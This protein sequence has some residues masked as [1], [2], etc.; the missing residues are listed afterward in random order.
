MSNYD[1]ASKSLDN[2]RT[3]IIGGADGFKPT[4]IITLGHVAGRMEHTE[5][6]LR[7]EQS[8]HIVKDT[9]EGEWP[10]AGQMVHCWRAGEW[11]SHVYR[12]RQS[13]RS[14]LW[15]PAPPPPEES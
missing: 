11:E 14:D 6:M 12:S 1:G 10:E 5:M 15:L 3:I 13:M 8:K 4:D 7:H 2:L 9:R